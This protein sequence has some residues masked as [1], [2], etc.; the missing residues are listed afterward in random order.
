MPRRRVTPAEY[1]ESQALL[2][3]L[4][5]G[6]MIERLGAATQ[7]WSNAVW[8][9]RAGALDKALESVVA[10]GIEV[11]IP[12]KVGRS[13]IRSITE[14]AGDLLDAELPDDDEPELANE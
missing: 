9:V 5:L 6:D 4:I 3:P 10:V 8:H 7:A 11:D 14:R 1:I 13:E 12:M 2:V